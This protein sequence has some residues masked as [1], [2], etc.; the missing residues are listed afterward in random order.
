MVVV[1][2]SCGGGARWWLVAE[3]GGCGVCVCVWGV[4]RHGPWVCIVRVRVGPRVRWWSCGGD[5][6]VW[7]CVSCAWSCVSAAECRVQCVRRSVWDMCLWGEGPGS[8][9]RPGGRAGG[10]GPDRAGTGNALRARSGAPGAACA[11]P[12]GPA[13]ARRAGRGA[14]GILDTRA[15]KIRTCALSYAPP[16]E[17]MLLDACPLRRSR[18]LGTIPPGRY[19]YLPQSRP[20][21]ALHASRPPSRSRAATNTPRTPSHSRP[22]PTRATPRPGGGTASL[23]PSRRTASPSSSCSGRGRGR[24]VSGGC[25]GHARATR[26]CTGPSSSASEARQVGHGAAGVRA[27]Q[28]RSCSSSLPSRSKGARALQREMPRAL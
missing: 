23:T 3:V 2:V 19:S 21:E 18:P 25:T 4:H 20:F 9:P 12:R 8:P 11:R 5:D 6:R 15:Q 14:E 28:A 16:V 24:H 17:P 10:A 13:A 26:R 27:R 7:V 1:G 22:P